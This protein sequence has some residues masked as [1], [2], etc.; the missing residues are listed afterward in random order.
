MN[1]KDRKKNVRHKTLQKIIRKG[2]RITQM[3][4]IR[5]DQNGFLFFFIK[6]TKDRIDK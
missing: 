4:R 3:E 1:S 2:T 6:R 5:T